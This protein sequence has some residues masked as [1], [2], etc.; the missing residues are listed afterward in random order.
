MKSFHVYC[1]KQKRS[2]KGNKQTRNAYTF[3]ILPHPMAG[4]T[5]Q[6]QNSFQLVLKLTDGNP[7]LHTRDETQ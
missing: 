1:H 2:D 4:V 7:R 3:A 6:C 5:N